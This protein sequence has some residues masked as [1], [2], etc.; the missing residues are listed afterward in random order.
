MTKLNYQ[1]GDVVFR[2]GDPGNHVCL[3]IEGSVDVV[4]Q[5]DDQEVLLGTVGAGEFV[6]E[7]GVLENQ[8]RGATVR[9]R[10]AVSV[11]VLSEEEFL[12]RISDDASAALGTLRRLSE[13]LRSVNDRLLEATQTTGNESG[14]GD[15]PA[16]APAAPAPTAGRPG[17][18]EIFP[19]SAQ[20]VRDLP[21]V[22]VR[23]E[24][25]PF[26]VGREPGWRERA[27]G[28]PVALQLRDAMPYRLSRLHFSI[29]QQEDAYAVRDIGSTLGTLVNDAF[30]G[31]HASGAFAVLQP[32]ENRVVAGGLDSPFAFRIVVGEA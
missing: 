6:G 22:G 8:P 25:F 2:E 30:I 21:E 14:G 9:A 4:K 11:E 28:S 1:T 23:I 24:S 31:Q 20:V 13:R 29:V 5:I 27:P 16:D 10:E 18:I 17:T 12:R 32:G 26:T 15:T 19:G 3:V 7:M